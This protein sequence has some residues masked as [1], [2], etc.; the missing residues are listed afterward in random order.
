MPVKPAD[1]RIPE[2]LQVYAGKPGIPRRPGSHRRLLCVADQ[3]RYDQQPGG[4]SLVAA[5][6]SNP[7]PSRGIRMADTGDPR[8]FEL[9]ASGKL[10]RGGDRSLVYSAP[11]LVSE[12]NVQQPTRNIQY[13]RQIHKNLVGWKFLVGYWIF[14]PSKNLMSLRNHE[15]P[16]KSDS[17]SG[18]RGQPSKR[19]DA[20]Y[21]L[22]LAFPLLSCHKYGL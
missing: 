6:A 14:S 2:Y 3:C 18:L 16:L 7:Q 22:R 1:K 19:A 10:K 17:T 5:I 4:R 15:A 9:S 20:D 21:R 8:A 11:T 12:N 13:P